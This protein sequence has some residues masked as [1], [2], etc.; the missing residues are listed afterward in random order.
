MAAETLIVGQNGGGAAP[1]ADADLIKETTTQNFR[2]DVL[3]A[4]RSVPVLVDF[5]A[6][7]CGPCRQLTPVLEKAVRNARGKVL[8]VKMNIDDHPQIAGQLGVQSIPAVIAFKNGQPLDGFMG[9]LPESQVTAFIER[10]AGPTGPSDSER[11]QEAAAAALA[12][13]DF[14]GAAALY[15]G[16]LQEAPDNLAALGGLVR[17][18]V[19]LDELPQARGLVSGLTPEQQKDPAISAALTALE[20]AEQAESLG[21]PTE[22]QRRLDANPSDHQA[23]LD[24]AVVLNGRGDRAGAAEQLLE[25]V[26]RDRAWNEEGARK[27]LVQFFEAWGAKDPAAIKGRQRLSSILFS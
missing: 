25:I 20:L 14:P 7:W 1:K 23:R 27:Q 6:P 24:L 22:L 11:A 19:G 2:T 9:A 21:N 5:W 17:C 10:I 8:L 4:S 15:A 16:V 13:K 3:E 18:Y 26:R 12:V